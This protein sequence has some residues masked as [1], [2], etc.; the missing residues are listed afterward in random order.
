[1]L[2][3]SP[4]LSATEAVSVVFGGRFSVA[5]KVGFGL[6]ALSILA[7]GARA[8]S[9]APP[10]DYMTPT[11]NGQYELV[12]LP[13]TTYARKDD[14]LRKR[15]R[16]SG[17]YRKGAPQRALWTIDW[18]A[19]QVYPA[20]DGHHLV[21]MGPW[22]SS[23]ED[24]AVAFYRDGRLLHQFKINQLVKDPISLPHSV[25]HF[26]WAK[27][28]VFN[29]AKRQLRVTT[30]AGE[31]YLFDGEGR[32]LEGKLVPPYRPK[33]RA[34]ELL[35]KG[36]FVGLARLGSIAFPEIVAA[37]RTGKGRLQESAFLAL[38]AN[39]KAALPQMAVLSRDNNPA[40]R[41]MAATGLTEIAAPETKPILL[42][43]VKDGNARVRIGAIAGLV[44]IHDAAPGSPA[45][46]AAQSILRSGSAAEKQELL[47][48]LN[49]SRVPV[50]IPDVL[51][52]LLYTERANQ[53]RLVERA[54][55]WLMDT[56]FQSF[57]QLE[58]GPNAYQKKAHAWQQW[59]ETN[60]SRTSDEWFVQAI[61]RDLT[62]L[63]GEE[64]RAA[65]SH[66]ER[67]SGQTFDTGENDSQANARWK[68]WWQN[69]KAK[70]PGQVLID[71]LRPPH[72]ADYI[73]SMEGV[74][75]L[76]LQ[77]DERD[78]AGLVALYQSDAAEGEFIQD[79]VEAA[80]RRITNVDSFAL[81]LFD[82]QR[83]Q[84]VIQAWKQFAAAHK[85]PS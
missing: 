78:V 66:L 82:Q 33:S 42:Q 67:L 20:S 23:P 68:T 54:N 5:R 12:M 83:K 69:N 2:S 50:L 62:F 53:G 58:S 56:T 13:T 84:A 43:L 4:L 79:Y 7:S 22:A 40:M 48:A 9:A 60:K 37:V 72:K 41:M 77:C 44:Q 39:G 85:Q 32:L 24:L 75:Q 8:D 29:D 45:I 3:L 25:S 18:Y 6:W 28:I 52:L 36:D 38:C 46:Q 71:S 64:R 34:D 65:V 70:R 59:W 31:K 26:Q 1:M 55:Y 73:P 16:R 14:K 11:A 80:L 19:F 15:Y 30:L 61:E 49:R 51:P 21:R 27:S 76:P 47:Y 81:S 35:H 10:R 74:G 63:S 17:L 57:E